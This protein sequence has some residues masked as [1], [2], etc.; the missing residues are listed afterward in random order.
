MHENHAKK[1][2]LPLPNLQPQPTDWNTH[3][4]GEKSFYKNFFY[5]N[6]HTYIHTPNIH[7]YLKMIRAT[8]RSF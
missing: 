6:I 5:P 3:V 1:L 2:T 4:W 7:T 8:R